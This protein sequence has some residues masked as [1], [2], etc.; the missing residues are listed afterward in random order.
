MY[1]INRVM[2]NAKPKH[3]GITVDQCAELRKPPHINPFTKRKLNPNALHGVYKKLIKDCE[4]IEKGLIAIVNKNPMKPKETKAS[5]MSPTKLK[6]LKKI[7]LRM[8]LRNALK[9]IL[10]R[11]DTHDNRIYFT[12]VIRKYNKHIAPCVQ[13]SEERDNTLTLVK[14]E[15]F[16]PVGKKTE[17]TRVK[18]TIYF[19]KR[20]G[21]DS[22]YGTAYMNTGRGI[23]R[24]L[25]FSIKI[26]SD[27]F[28]DEVN[29]L[30]LMSSLAETKA[31]PN[32]PIT[33]DVLH[34]TKL[35]K[36]EVKT[37]RSKITNPSKILKIGRYYVVLS[38]LANG[39]MN[40]FFLQQHTAEV[41]ESVIMQVLISLST[42]HSYSGYIHNDAHLGNFLF[43]KIP[44][45]GYWHYEI[46]H[47][48]PLTKNTETVD[49]FV[50]NTGYLVVLW[51][52]G[53]AQRINY[54][55]RVEPFVDFDRVLTLMGNI[56]RLPDYRNKGMKP[57]PTNIFG[58][59][60]AMHGLLYKEPNITLFD[61][62]AKAANIKN[63]LL[64]H[65]IFHSKNLPTNHTILNEK[66]YKIYTK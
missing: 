49:M 61:I 58:P 36:N 23:G 5:M 31:S 30:K 24:A 42:F 41:Y 15:K 53:L 34:C 39:D 29:M 51:D 45:G 21:S 22:V 52:P 62:I 14:H 1:A 40:D 13:A 46:E 47:E 64:N 11:M 3:S 63:K 4:D 6:Q 56:A 38:E 27:Q 33:Y 50:P 19:K 55:M 65:I 57:I 26:M 18:E 8:A 12:K 59:F 7:R 20:I 60:M 48:N 54:N 44:P 43:H 16:V 37:L 35:S 10:N 66:P 2:K 32:M 17:E 28:T 25:K 9:P